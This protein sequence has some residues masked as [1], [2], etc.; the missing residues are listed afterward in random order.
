MNEGIKQTFV[1]APVRK[2]D[3]MSLVTGQP[4]YT[5]DL[6]PRDCL[7]VKV[8]RSPHANAIIEDINTVAAKRVPGI[9][10]ILTYKDVPHVRFTQ[11]GQ[12]HPEAS[13][14]DR[15]VL[16]DHVRFIGDEVA[17]VAGETEAACDKALKLIKVKYKVL[18]AVLDFRTALD[19][20]ILVHPEEDWHAE[21]W[22]QA[23]N[24]RNLV[25]HEDDHDG[26]VD[27][28]LAQCDEVVEGTYHTRANAQ[29]MMETFRT[30]CYK[31][32]YGR[33]VILSSTQIPFHVRRIVANALNI[34]KAKIRVV[35]PRI[36]GGFGA[37]QSAM[38]ERIPAIV[39]WL[40]GKPSMIISTREESFVA[41]CPR[42]E[43][44]I[45][46]R[47][48]AMK[49]GT[50]RAIDMYALSNTGAYSEHG[51]TVVSLAGHK[52]I[53]LYSENMEAFRFVADVVYTNIGTNGAF[54][55]YGAPQ[56]LFALEGAVNELAHKLNIDPC[57]IRE[58]N[59]LREG[60][61]MP[62]YHHDMNYSCTMD[63]CMKR[64]K[65]LFHWDERASVRTLPNGHIR[66]AGVAM[67]MQGSGISNMDVGNAAIRLA[68]DGIYVLN[69]GCSDMGTGCDTILAQMAADCL[70]TD[71]DNILVYSVDTDTS[72]YD[73]GSYASS[74]TYITG[75]AVVKASMKLRE[76][77]LDVAAKKLNCPVDQLSMNKENVV[78]EATGASISLGEI[79]YAAQNGMCEVLTATAGHFSP[80]S[81]P[82]YMV[83]MCEIDIDPDTGK[84][85]PIEY[86]GVIDCGTVINPNLAR[87]QAEGGIAQGIGMALY[88]GID[89]TDRGGLIQKNF[90]QYKIPSRM[91]VGK[92]VVDF[93]PSYEP[94]GPFGAKS[95]GEL[96]IDTPSPALA[97]A[98]Y[99]ATGVMLKDLPMTPEMVLNSLL[100]GKL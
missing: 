45:K 95:I 6:A 83:G 62:A 96:V 44:E 23:D 67:A 66:S 5:E 70:E 53:P 82:P 57:V 100:D 99:N 74:T 68:D 9:E 84:V 40:T 19:N 22:T 63:R 54:R 8:L 47:V 18:D 50:I 28:V 98:I 64:A 33:L 4:V 94:T 77:I 80:L 13:P 85:T 30:C 87:V 73:S 31:D 17:I 75:T 91:D 34:S 24:K 81:P 29:A 32:T 69:I 42:H 11:A 78:N 10:C 61:I 49:D 38:Y 76:M 14:K 16:E 90:L 72:P 46:V 65:E 55:G 59:M 3:A 89:F 36:G 20:P 25:Y 2:K 37:K 41:G 71:V 88:E 27:A 35:K 39:T 93:E 26:D 48:G 43:M 15:Y 60:K 52:T 92:I 51:P 12:T 56:G 86:V 21:A 97:D 1:N 7:V 79:G 58:K